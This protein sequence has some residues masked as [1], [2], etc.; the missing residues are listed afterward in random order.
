MA[1]LEI[2]LSA[3][4]ARALSELED[5]TGSRTS[6]IIG[7]ALNDQY[8]IHQ[9][10]W[11]D[12]ARSIGFKVISRG[13]TKQFH[14]PLAERANARQKGH[15]K[16]GSLLHRVVAEPKPTERGAKSLTFEQNDEFAAVLA[17][18]A[19]A[20]RL[21]KNRVINQAILDARR[22][23][24]VTVQGNTLWYG[25]AVTGKGN[26]LEMGISQMVTDRLTRGAPT[27]REVA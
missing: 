10:V 21:S 3:E 20:L 14:F 11:T 5:L 2:T 13:A 16:M 17:A 8:S 7:T 9:S 15:H 23:A 24:D 18:M 26:L 12:W 6:L 4:A 19:S 1:K 25:N 22:V 27:S